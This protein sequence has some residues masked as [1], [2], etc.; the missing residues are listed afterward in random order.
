MTRNGVRRS[1]DGGTSWSVVLNTSDPNC[2]TSRGAD[3]EIGADNTIYISMGIFSEG[4]IFRSTTGNSGSW[5]H[6]SPGGN[7]FPTTGVNRI[8][9]ACAPSNSN[10]VYA[11]TQSSSS[12]GVQGLYRSSDQGS[13]WTSLTN[14]VDA[15]GGIGSDFTRGQ[16]WYDLIASVDPN[17]DN[18][19]YIGGVDLFK[20]TNGGTSW[21]Q[22]AHWYG[23]FGFPYVHADQH[24]I[25]FKPGSSTE[26]I[27]GNDGGVAYTANGTSGTPSFTIRNE[28]Y[29]VTQYYACAI[30]P[31]ACTDY[32]LAG[33]QDNGSQQYTTAGVNATNEVT[34]GDGCFTHID[35]TD[36]NY[37]MTSYVYNNYYRTTNGGGTWG[38]MGT[39][40]NSGYFVNPT[41]YDNNQDI[42]YGARNATTLRRITNVT[43][44]PSTGNVTIP[45]MG[46]TATAITVS[47]YTTASTT[48]FLAY[49]GGNILKVTNANGGSPSSTD[50]D[51]SGTLPGGTISCIEVGSSEN[52]LLVVFSN[53]GITSVYYTSDGGTTWLN[54][55]GS[56]PDM[57]VRW[58]LFNPDNYNEVILATEVGVWSTADLSA[59]SP[60]W[61]PSNSGLAN[62]S[63]HMLQMRESDNQVIAATH[64][65]GLFSGYFTS[66]SAADVMLLQ[67]E[68]PGVDACADPL[69]IDLKVRNNGTATLTSMDITW[70]IDGGSSTVY[71][72]TGSLAPGEIATVNAG[73]FTTSTGTHTINVTLSNPNGTSDADPSDNALSDTFDAVANPN[74]LTITISTDCWGYESGV[75]LQDGGGATVF[76]IAA[77]TL[78]NQQTYTY[79]ICVSDGC[80]DLTITDSFG[81]GMDGVSSGCAVNGSYQ[82]EDAYGNILATIGAVNFGTSV[83]HNFCVPVASPNTYYSVASGNMSD[84][85]WD[86]D[87][88]GAGGTLTMDCTKDLIIQAGH[89]VTND[90]GDFNIQNFSIE[91]TGT[92]NLGSANTMSL[93]G[94]LTTDGTMNTSDSR[95][96]F[97]GS[98]M[99]TIGGT[100]N[101]AFFDVMLDN[102]SGLQLLSD[103]SIFGGLDL[104]A[105]NFDVNGNVWTFGSN[106][107]ATG[108]LLQIQPG[109]DFIG[110]AVCQNYISSSTT[111]WRMI[112]TS[113]TGSTIDNQWNDD[114][115]TTGFTGSDYPGYGFVNVRYYDE[116]LIGLQAHYDSGFYAPT[117]VSNVIDALEACFFYMNGLPMAIDNEG[118]PVK[119]ALSIPVTYTNSSTVLFNDGWNLVA[120]SYQS[121]IDWDAASGWSR[122]NIDGAI[123]AWDND[124]QQWASYTSGGVGTN[125]GSRYLAPQQGYWIK[126]N[127]ASPAF[128]MD[129]NVKVDQYVAYIRETEEFYPQS[130]KL[131][132]SGGGI[133][134]EMGIAVHAGAS[135]GFDA[136]YDAYKF[137]S[138]NDLAPSLYTVVPD[139]EGEAELSIFSVSQLEAGMVIPIYAE[140]GVDGEYML[141]LSDFD[142]QTFGACLML[143]DLMLETLTPVT[144]GSNYSFDATIE[145]DAHRFNIRVEAA[146][147][148]DVNAA[149]CSGTPDGT[150][151]IELS[152]QLDGPFTYTW[153]DSGNLMIAEITTD[154]TAST[155]ED[156][157]AGTYSVTV[158]GASETCDGVTRTFVVEQPEIFTIS[159]MDSSPASC[160]V[161]ANGMISMHVN[162]SDCTVTIYQNDELYDTFAFEGGDLMISDL[163]AGY[164][165]VVVSNACGNEHY[166]ADLY[167]TFVVT[168]MFEG[169]SVIDLAQGEILELTNTSE[170]AANYI[171]DLGNGLTLFSLTDIQYA[172]DQEGTYMVTLHADNGRCYDMHQMEVTVLGIA[173]SNQEP[174]A[175]AVQVYTANGEVIISGLILS[176]TKS[177]IQITDINGKLVREERIGAASGSTMRISTAGITAGVYH[178]TVISNKERILTSK[179]YIH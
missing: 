169:S 2:N 85:I 51:P 83:T 86:T 43:G 122:T 23:G 38:G 7:G 175:E 173:N 10:V 91:N 166:V 115:P 100:A 54:K 119:G 96:S 99:Q 62:V 22:V 34:G 120:N 124:L 116:T 168:A 161:E 39:G 133:N 112:G 78:G 127:A 44:A 117:D 132:L 70:D 84:P 40:E 87:P 170:N 45:S 131:L 82:M 165:E 177:L 105:G 150:A 134:D 14:P 142:T 75:I 53:Y 97:E 20:T 157:G 147:H 90:L 135:A 104:Q 136:V 12:Y 67:I 178:V 37:Q 50:I 72:W 89:T 94:N 141:S 93:C 48:L 5:T 98:A 64:G 174:I 102:S 167:D 164:Y 107:T 28:D 31:D 29:N 25:H 123:Y 6:L 128:G 59:G 158:S 1:Q 95:V 11:I 140:V 146:A 159:E 114:L 151:T 61:V 110:N 80:Y 24:A 145:D 68:S 71:A 160:N 113:V 152:T 172:Y 74:S 8:E 15:D 55:E 118:A 153:Y 19:V 57:P 79:S 126:A 17:D 103:Q 4:D 81:D 73:T 162:G 129:E 66:N 63:V 47:P 58:A 149:S 137:R 69:P 92:F 35:Q 148:I 155:L 60:T 9:L 139:G 13:N 130:F 144:S 18:T 101:T 33:A 36:P 41:D 21:T 171:W 27:F 143:E 30:H 16:A 179:Q 125:G 88:G 3:I 56:L 26:I 76:S 46:G 108:R 156:L 65:R 138:S 176:N 49:G 52:E 106:S 32:Y 154:E 111:G 42:I 77:N 109:A 163:S 121:T